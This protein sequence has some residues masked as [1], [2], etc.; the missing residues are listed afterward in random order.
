[1]RARRHQQRAN[2]CDYYHPLTTCSS[3]GS[4]F[5][6]PTHLFLPSTQNWMGHFILIEFHINECSF[7]Y[8]L[9]PCG[10]LRLPAIR[11]SACSVF[12]PPRTSAGAQP[13]S[14]R[15]NKEARPLERTVPWGL[16]MLPRKTQT[17]ARHSS[18]SRAPSAPPEIQAQLQ[19]R[20]RLPR[21]QVTDGVGG[22]AGHVREKGGKTREPVKPATGRN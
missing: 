3:I 8:K 10:N 1:M 16:G 6:P 15:R 5:T 22:A 4:T 21:C 17:L 2:Y 12:P 11:R 13:E 14:S 7:I 20:E 19:V 9:G 18:V